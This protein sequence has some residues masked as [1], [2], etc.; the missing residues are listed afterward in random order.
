MARADTLKES[1]PPTFKKS[2]CYAFC[3]DFKCAQNALYIY[4]NKKTNKKVAGCNFAEDFCIG[5]KCK[6]AAC[7]IRKLRPDGGCGKSTQKQRAPTPDL[8][9]DDQ[10]DENESLVRTYVRKSKALK[11]L[12]QIDLD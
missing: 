7:N 1:R 3:R 2:F 12:K 4:R 9:I 6:Y 10:E 5:Y 8:W 11:K